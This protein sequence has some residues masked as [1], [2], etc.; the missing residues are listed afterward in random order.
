MYGDEMS[1]VMH[2]AAPVRDGDKIIG[3]LTVAKPNSAVQP[4][5]E[6]SQQI[7]LHR[8]ALLLGLS[9]LIGGAFAW[10]LTHSLRK[11]MLYIADV[12]AGKKAALLKRWATTRSVP[13]DGRSRPCVK[14]SRARSTWRS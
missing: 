7:I 8:G 4:F 13:W 5:V 6:R 10:W 2:V 11:L 12:E 1:T 9:L 14:S 3:V